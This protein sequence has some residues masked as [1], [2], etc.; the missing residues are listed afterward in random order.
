MRSDRLRYADGT[1]HR[2]EIVEHAPTYGIIAL[3]SPRELVLV[4]QYRHP[5]RRLLWEIPAGTAE[6]GEDAKTGALRELAEETGYAAARI[7][8]LWNLYMTPGFCDERMEFFV[9]RDLRAGAQSLDEDERI[10]VGCFDVR[11]AI[12][13][14]E[15]GEVADVKTLL[16]LHWIAA[17]GGE[18]APGSVDRKG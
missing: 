17:Q 13:L 4:R 9:A 1:D 7:E 16:A 8:P 5:V 3:C 11:E 10:E 15:R 2:C 14:F 12:A 6:P 18:L